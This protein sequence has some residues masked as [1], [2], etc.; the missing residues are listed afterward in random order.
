MT[1]PSGVP[2]FAPDAFLEGCYRQQD[3]RLAM[4]LDDPNRWPSWHQ[5]LTTALTQVLGEVGRPLSGGADGAPRELERVERPG[6]VRRRVVLDGGQ[7]YAIPAYVLEPTG[8]PA[9]KA[10]IVAVHGHGYGSRELVGLGPD[11]A[12]RSEPTYQKDFGLALVRKGFVVVCPELL[13]FGDRR[14]P[15]D[16]ATG[17]PAQ[18]SCE[19]IA[20]NLLLC[21][22]TMAGMRLWDVTRSIDYLQSRPDVDGERIGAMGISGGGTV[23]TLATALDQRV[24][25][26]V[27]SGYANTFRDS[28]MAMHHCVDNYLPGILGLAEMAD[29]LGLIAPRPLLLEAGTRDPLFPVAAARRTYTRLRRAYA[30]VGNPGA[31]RLDVFDGEHQI[32]GAQ[33]YDFLAEHLGHVTGGRSVCHTHRRSTA[34]VV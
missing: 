20:M 6:Y 5:E 7:D 1:E 32:W 19:R 8:G 33:A 24:K 28:I 21:G 27:I 34:A 2:V 29:I 26:A 10:G 11:G 17:D 13:G 9:H 22:R 15:E 14:L 18:S 31:V 4:P 30:L 12:E 16:V 25:A 23:T 3:Q